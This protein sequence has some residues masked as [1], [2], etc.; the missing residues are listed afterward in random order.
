MKADF[1]LYLPICSGLRKD[2]KSESYQFKFVR[3]GRFMPSDCTEALILTFTSKTGHFVGLNRHKI[4]VYEFFCQNE[5]IRGM[6]IKYVDFL[7]ISKL[8]YDN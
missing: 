3:F 1:L 6:S 7:N 5:D 2:H 4:F 8:V